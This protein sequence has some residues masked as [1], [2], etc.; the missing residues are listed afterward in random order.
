[1]NVLIEK[2]TSDNKIAYITLFIGKEDQPKLIPLGSDT[3][4]M[5]KVIYDFES[6]DIEVKSVNVPV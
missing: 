4:F 3:D 1:M 6:I 5:K 2:V